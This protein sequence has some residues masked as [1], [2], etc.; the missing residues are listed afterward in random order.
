MRLVL[1]LASV[2][3]TLL[4][5]KAIAQQDTLE[6]LSQFRDCDACPEMIVIPA[7][8]FKMGSPL[9]ERDRDRR[10]EN[11]PR[12]VKIDNSFAIGVYD[13]TVAEWNACVQAKGC[14]KTEDIS[15]DDRRPMVTVN[16]G[17]ITSFLNWLSSKAH[18]EYRLPSEAEWEYAARAG[19]ESRYNWG[20]EVGID[21]A[22]CD[23]CNS[24]AR[25]KDD[26]SE[27]G[28]FPANNWHLYDMAGNVWQLTEDC[29]QP[30]PSVIDSK[31]LETTGCTQ[32]V[33][34]GGGFSSDP[35]QIRSANRNFVGINES[36]FADIGFRVATSLK[37]GQN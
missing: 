6:P 16:Y 36:G 4:A 19:S 9:T 37:G 25:A 30:H 13:V 15:Q 35:S 18:R 1:V 29:F 12:I 8:T 24:P 2:C 3:V 11:E 27:V 14:R 20:N 5:S 23:G 34:R 32:R 22:L 26:R 21:N 17:D 28:K 10:N 7:G 33:I 31:H